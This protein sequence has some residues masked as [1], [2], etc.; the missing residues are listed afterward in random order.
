MSDAADPAQLAALRPSEPAEM[1]REHQL[2]AEIAS[3][4]RELGELA[5]AGGDHGLGV[6]AEVIGD[7]AGA[8]LWSIGAVMRDEGFTAT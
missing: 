6:I 1:T 8:G 7:H 3:C 4:A 2:L 5:R